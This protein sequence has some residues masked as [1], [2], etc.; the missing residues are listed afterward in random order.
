[1]KDAKTT[2]QGKVWRQDMTRS[3]DIF[4]VSEIECRPISFWVVFSNIYKKKSQVYAYHTDEFK[5]NF[6]NRKGR[7][8]SC[9]YI[10]RFIK[11]TIEFAINVL[12]Y[13]TMVLIVTLSRQ[14]LH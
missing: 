6:C 12:M 14:V 7:D 11:G 13:R 5:I 10:A 8:I 4:L 9:L 2:I 1:M 3:F